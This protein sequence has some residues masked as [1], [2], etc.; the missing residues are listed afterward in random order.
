MRR[1][2]RVLLVFLLIIA[3]LAW[4][5]RP[6]PPLVVRVVSVGMGEV[7]ETVVNSRAGTV[8]A[9]RRAAL[10][11][12]SGG[13]VARLLVAEGDRVEAGALILALWNDDRKARVALAREQV[14]A[15]RANA[16]E[17]CVLA[18]SAERERA[19]VQRLHQQ[20]LAPDEQWDQ[21][22]SQAEAQ[23]ARCLA[24][25][26][27][28][29]VAEH[30]LAVAEAD[31]ERTRLRAP[32]AGEVAQVN[33]GVGEYLAPGARAPASP[34]VDLIDR[35]CLYVSAPID[36]VDATRLAPGLGV[37]V[38][39]DALGDR[40]FRGRIVR[41]APFVRTV[42]KQARTV[43]VRVEW[44][45]EV[46]HVPLLPGYSADVEVI[47]QRRESVLR[48]PTE[49]VVEGRWVWLL[50]QDGR[51]RRRPVETGLSNWRWTEVRRGLQAEERVVLPQQR[52]A[53]REGRK[54]VVAE[55]ASE[56]GV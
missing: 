36:E 1:F 43:E 40:V 47:L 48:I 50:G 44:A 18:D 9:C 12:P 55:N 3:A 53:L 2:L 34:A 28:V 20:G 30:Q 8:K 46:D 42:E 10:S 15:A 41:V 27:Q 24:L 6:P 13:V 22:R 37:R 5:W 56:E 19:R 14:S 31:L 49:T 29:Q 52:E 21:A 32:F 4:W 38:T 51:L 23:R 54:A 45:G 16:R 17:A 39:L 25:K 26:A 33:V 7:A 11:P 35:S